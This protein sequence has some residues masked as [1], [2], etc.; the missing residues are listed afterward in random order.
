MVKVCSQAFLNIF[1]LLVLQVYVN[2]KRIYPA[3]SN[4]VLRL[5][6][7]DM[8]ITLEIPDISTKVVYRGTTFSIDL[9]SSLF[10][11]N[12]EG[13]CGELPEYLTLDLHQWCAQGGVFFS[14]LPFKKSVDVTDLHP[15]L[16][17]ASPWCLSFSRNL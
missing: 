6:S 4:S 13:Q 12:T 8:V 17:L 3:Y 16:A 9:P 15:D 5:T 2:Q 7:T 1:C 10:K 14:P 11:G